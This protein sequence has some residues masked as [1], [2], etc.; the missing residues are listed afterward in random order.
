MIITDQFVYIHV[1]KTGG[2]SIH[3]TFERRHGLK[4]FQDLHSTYRDIPK[5]MRDGRFVWGIMR[6][7]IEQEA[8]NWR[9][10]AHFWHRDGNPDGEMM[11]FE[12]WLEWKY[13]RPQEWASKWLQPS[14]IDYGWSL[15]YRPQ[16]G[17]F[18]DEDGI[19]K[20]DRIYRFDDLHAV[21]QEIGDRFGYNLDLE[22]H[23]GMVY[24]WSRNKRDYAE[25]ATPRAI[26][27][28]RK[29]RAIDFELW[30]ADGDIRTD[31][32]CPTVPHYAYAR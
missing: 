18:C 26:E 23:K 4:C 6:D 19:C 15:N 13:I 1:M 22:E 27:L 25:H 10:H 29:F 32:V 2:T 12:Q 31:Y 20:A 16:A 9:Y 28:L 7:P 11:P 5:D 21:M 3:N 17:Y 14:H 30:E 24:Q 8:S